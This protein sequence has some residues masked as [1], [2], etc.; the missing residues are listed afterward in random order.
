MIAQA[1]MGALAKSHMLICLSGYIDR[2][3]I[4]LAAA[5]AFGRKLPL[6]VA[7]FDLIE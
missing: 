3:V 7:V 1:Q 4:S 2:P 6:K 5:A